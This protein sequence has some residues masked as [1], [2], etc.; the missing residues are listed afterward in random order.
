[1]KI[2]I[3]KNTDFKAIWDCNT[4]SYYVYKNNHLILTAFKFS[5]IQ[6]YLN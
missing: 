1:M 3:G 2:F 4:Q 6:S 5:N